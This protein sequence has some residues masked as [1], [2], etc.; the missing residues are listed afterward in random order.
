MNHAPARPLLA[1]TGIVLAAHVLLLRAPQDEFR[2]T[3]P[4]F[5]RSLVMRTLNFEAPVAPNA[6]VVA[7]TPGPPRR[8]IMRH[9]DP[10]A[11]REP[12]APPPNAGIPSSQPQPPAAETSNAAPAEATPLPAGTPP[13]AAFA[14]P[15]SATLHYQVN[16]RARGQDWQARG[17]L[18]WRHDGE[19]YDAKLAL[20]IPLLPLRTQHSTGRITPEGLAPVR[21]SDKNRSEQATHFER[22]KGKV[23]FSSN[24]PDAPLLVGAQDRLSVILQLASMIAGDPR[25]FPQSTTITIPTAGTRETEP[26]I[27]TVEGDEELLLPGG[28]VAALKLLRNPRKE[29]DLK[30]E[31]WLAPA[32]DYVP[33]RVRLTQPNGDWADQ[34]W[35]STDRG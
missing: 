21:Y 23:T 35:S 17:E 19:R 18:V 34:Q 16:V 14:I 6:P 5:S 13:A 11:V 25:K 22:D 3:E 26:W 10:A 15:G 33:V 28:K 32:M 12:D 4:V 8:P 2:P 7:R 27:F 29:F 1:L 20:N 31:L 24:R 30:I 9:V